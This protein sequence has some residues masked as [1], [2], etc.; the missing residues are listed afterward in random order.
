MT[1]KS[2][3]RPS[4]VLIGG[5]WRVLEEPAAA[6]ESEAVGEVVEPG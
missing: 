2:R 4:E 6:P 1:Y 3:Y 5:T